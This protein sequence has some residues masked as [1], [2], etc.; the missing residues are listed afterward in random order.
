M[1]T[2]TGK[3]V[4]LHLGSGFKYYPGWLNVDVVGDQ[5]VI[6]DLRDLPF[7]DEYADKIESIHVFEHF[8]R[9]DIPIVLRE[10]ARVL[11]TGGTLTLEM[12]S[13][14][15]IAQKIVDG[16]KNLRLTLFGLFGDPNYE[17]Q[18]MRHKWCWS[19]EELAMELSRFGFIDIHFSDAQY[20]VPSR[21]MRVTCKK[22]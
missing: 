22:G 12:P 6:S 9:V 18:F 4:R 20:H 14:E 8:E 17:S 2:T 1:E 13:L 15:K 7:D 19:R 16:E 11:K 21:D 5:D 3:P 10:W